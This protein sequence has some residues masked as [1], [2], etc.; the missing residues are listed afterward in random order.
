MQEGVV[1]AEHD[2]GKRRVLGQ[3]RL[4]HHCASIATLQELH[5]NPRLGGE[6]LK[7]GVTD[8]E[9]VVGHQRHRPAIGQ[10]GLDAVIVAARRCEQGKNE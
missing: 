2:V 9:G 8:D 3:D 1:D 5:G 7:H 10:R 4:A 6:R